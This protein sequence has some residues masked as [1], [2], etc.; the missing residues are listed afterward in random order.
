MHLYP[1]GFEPSHLIDR[2]MKWVS[3]PFPDKPI[4]CTEGGYS[5]DLRN[6]TRGNP[7]PQDVVALYTPRHW[8]EHALRTGDGSNGNAFV[9]YELL[10]DPLPPGA[11]DSTRRESSFGLIACPTT[12]PATWETKPSFTATA[13][14]MNLLADPGP[15]FLAAPLAFQVTGSTNDYRWYLMQKRDGVYYLAVWRSVSS[16]NPYTRTRMTVE[17]VKLTVSFAIPK[18]VTLYI[19]NDGTAGSSRGRVSSLHIFVG[20]ELQVL[21]IG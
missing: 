10:D 21:R 12:D 3:L 7:V 18:P 17:R 9:R 4:A 16:W 1:Q 8:L 5:D 6:T 15:P 2:L 13:N 14:L 11:R 19:P 20:A